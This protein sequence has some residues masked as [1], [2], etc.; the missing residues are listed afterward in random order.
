MGT[1]DQMQAEIAVFRQGQPRDMPDDFAPELIDKG[2][3][4]VCERCAGMFVNLGFVKTG[5]MEHDRELIRRLRMAV[6]QYVELCRLG[7]D[8][9]EVAGHA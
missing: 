4:V 7:I 2:H 6:W 1:P 8:P 5:D 3:S 9:F